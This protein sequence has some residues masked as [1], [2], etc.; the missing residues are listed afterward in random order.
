M[1][2]GGPGHWGGGWRRFIRADGD[3]EQSFSGLSG[4]VDVPESPEP[5]APKGLGE[6]WR[7][8]VTS[9]RG[10]A[11]AF[12]R[13][14]SLVWQASAGATVML[15]VVTV[16]LGVLPAATAYT[17]KL[18]INAVLAGINTHGSA[19]A[20]LVIPLGPFTMRS[21]TTTT[22]GVVVMLAVIQLAIFAL[23]SLLG[24]VR[25][26]SQQLLQNEVQVRIQLM[27]MER[28]ARLDLPFFEDSYSY[29]LLR[30]A[31]QDSTG[32]PVQMISGA[33]GLLQTVITFVTMIALL[34]A[35]SPLLAVIALLA[36][37]PA[38]IADTRYGWIGFMISRWSS[39]ILR[40]MNYLVT[41]VTTD[42]NAKEV[43]LFE[44]GDYFVQRYRA[45]AETYNSRQRRLIR[46]RYLVGFAW[47]SLTLIAGSV[48]YLYVAL[49]A[50]AGRLTIGDLTLYTT[51]AT[52]VQG[53]IQGIL[54]G[55]SSMYE[56]N[57]YLS[58]LFELL[59][60]D[61]TI[62]PPEKPV[63]LPRPLR[64]ELRF[65]H[66]SFRY[67]GAVAEA[68]HDDSFTIEAGETIAIVGRNGAGK[69]TL[70]KLLC[71]LYDPTAGRILLDGIDLRDF[72]PDELRS[73]FGAMFQD[74]V[75]YQA[76]AAENVGLGE[77]GQI[78]DREAI[79]AAVVKGGASE[80]V[81]GLP[82]GLDT[83]LGKWFE[84][85]S[86]NLSGG[87]W[88]KIALSRAFMRDAKILF[89][90][91]PTSALDAQAEFD[92]FQRLRRLSR[93]KTAVYISHRFSTVRQADRILFFEQGR[94]VEEGTHGELMK[95]D[96]RYAK[97]F[98]LQA[99]AYTGEPVDA[100]I[101]DVAATPA[102]PGLR[103]QPPSASNAAAAI[104]S[105]SMPNSR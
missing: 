11:A 64:G 33:F 8:L 71:R 70:I 37:I 105:A 74:Y 89:L 39:P 38:F 90:D 10:G 46:S 35:V 14:L 6:R 69:S 3:R 40:R 48:T 43:K 62:L 79:N 72:D 1:I 49:L 4:S 15:G 75:T 68:L 65:E 29:D 92:L 66:V 78:E 22:T 94:L 55:F 17:A 98:R 88:Q 20:H 58:N 61:R 28:A 85:K 51:A 96:G 101:A 2:Q 73:V 32:R 36:P 100:A 59:A 86:S 16:L 50:I 13:V 47:Q 87:E 41:L 7:E 76:T 84:V 24:T 53:S 63:P 44:L 81:N 91:E 60:K 21:W 45:L 102:S 95:L 19:A 83:P 9:V 26:I 97:L 27:V 93:G 12:P 34:L 99:A 18:L 5:K 25:N 80:L 67:P 57:L 104:A 31:Q 56:H 30:R 42:N 103:N 23:N 52:S 82:Q 77:V 54:G